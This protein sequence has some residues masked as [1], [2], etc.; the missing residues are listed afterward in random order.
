MDKRSRPRMKGW[1]LF[2]MTLA[3]AAICGGPV[4]SGGLQTQGKSTDRL[5]KAKEGG[6]VE[7]PSGKAS[8]MIP[9]GSL[10]SDAR[11]SIQEIPAEGVLAAGPFFDIK[12]DGLKFLRPATMTIRFSAKDIPEGYSAEDMVIS[13]EMS[14]A[15]ESSTPSPSP[16][17]A[18]G[19]GLQ[20]G[21][22]IPSTAEA[23]TL[24]GLFFLDTNVTNSPGTVSAQIA[25]LS[26]YV[27]RAVSSYRLGTEQQL[28]QGTK[29][30]FNIIIHTHNVQGKGTA[31][32]G[33]KPDGYFS[34]STSVPLGEA[35]MAF[36]QAVGT[37]FFRVRP[38]AG[39]RGEVESVVEV[40][41]QHF[42][43][44]TDKTNSYNMGYSITLGARLPG[45]VMWALTGWPVF[46]SRDDYGTSLRVQGQ[47]P[48]GKFP[49]TQPGDGLFQQVFSKH[50]LLKGWFFP[51]GPEY[52][53]GRPLIAF[54][55][56]RLVAGRVYGLVIGVHTVVNGAK[57]SPGIPAMGG[58]VS[59]FDVNILRVTI[60][61]QQ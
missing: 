30:F 29:K 51:L 39:G 6:T 48:G 3:A 5:V 44:I 7:S 55:N 22:S 24:G 31:T 19:T 38:A 43:N 11:I 40:E 13:G 8:L 17:A 53:A 32:A 36:G 10:E 59:P 18:S 56:C 27:L 14:G 60:K 21:M 58:D 57:P 15:Q 4:L 25:H 9:A 23:V 16:S 45:N 28:V 34:I 49:G 1:I 35:G 12:P 33:C 50:P 2:V 52:I 46:S 42:A 47:K 41:M 20:A 61:A 37:K 26:K 54:K